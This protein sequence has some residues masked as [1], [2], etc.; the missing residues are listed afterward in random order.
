MHG[1]NRDRHGS[2]KRPL[3][4]QWAPIVYR[5]RFQRLRQ[6]LGRWTMLGTLALSLSGCTTFG[7]YLNNHFKVGPN[8][9]RPPAPV[10]EHWIDAADV[11]VR[12]ENPDT[13]RWWSVFHDPV[14][15]SL[16]QTA[17]QQNLTLREA[18]FRVL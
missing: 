1:S 10:A 11:R 7:E 12:S 17:S 2:G 13:S 16:V 15:D 8:Y 14:L 18:G 3:A 6:L 4:S 5:N 9:R